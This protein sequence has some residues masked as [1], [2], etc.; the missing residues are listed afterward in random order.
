M[1]A[2]KSGSLITETGLLIVGP[3]ADRPAPFTESRL[4]QA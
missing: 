2:T 4:L 3:P 1:L